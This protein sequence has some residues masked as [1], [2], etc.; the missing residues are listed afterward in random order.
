MPFSTAWIYDIT[1]ADFRRG[2]WG[3]EAQQKF[4]VDAIANGI[5]T[6]THTDQPVKNSDYWLDEYKKN[7]ERRRDVSEDVFQMGKIDKRKKA[8]RDA[9]KTLQLLRNYGNI[10]ELYYRREAEKEGKPLHWL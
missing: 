2:K 6:Y 7:V 9:Y 3:S 5:W 4:I 10:M 8:Y 1:D